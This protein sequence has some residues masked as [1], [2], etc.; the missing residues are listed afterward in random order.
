MEVGK[1]ELRSAT[2]ADAP[3]MI[4]IF[5]D[6]FRSDRH[7]RF[8]I[9]HGLDPA[10]GMERA[11]ASW[12]DSPRHDLVVAADEEGTALGWECWARHGYPPPGPGGQRTVHPDQE[13]SE[14][15][16]GASGAVRA[17]RDLTNRH[18]EEWRVTVMSDRT[19]C[20]ILT[21][22]C[23][24]P[25]VQS[26]GIGSLLVQWGTSRADEDGVLSW[27]PTSTPANTRPMR[28]AGTYSGTWSAN[29]RRRPDPRCPRLVGVP[30]QFAEH[31][32]DRRGFGHQLER[33]QHARAA[34]GRPQTVLGEVQVQFDRRAR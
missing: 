29:P 27:M 25:R 23:V 24:A 15:P 16:T 12:F 11:V 7:T 10:V 9:A 32:L 21:S 17:L 22:I 14:P 5:S 18:L 26:R 31:H 1:V 4:E 30:G 33:R 19:R 3:A 28:G 8:T 13:A 20:R 34:R 2:R 6:A